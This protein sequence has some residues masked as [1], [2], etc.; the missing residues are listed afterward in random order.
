VAVDPLGLWIAVMVARSLHLNGGEYAGR[1]AVGS[2]CGR[3]EELFVLLLHADA[4]R[5]FN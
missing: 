5:T 2:A 3:G 4:A 1:P